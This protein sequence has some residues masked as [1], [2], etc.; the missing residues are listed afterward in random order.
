MSEKVYQL[1]SNQIG[2]I[3]FNKPWLFVHVSMYDGQ[4]EL[5][6]FFPTL[7]I[8]VKAFPSIFEEVVINHWK[9]QGPQGEEKIEA[10]RQYMLNTWWNPGIETMR[11]SMYEQYGAAEF[12]EKS[13]K[14][15]LYDGFG[16]LGLTV[17][18]IALRLNNKH[19]YFEGLHI[20]ARVVDKFLSV[21]FWEKIKTDALAMIGTTQLK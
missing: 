4:S 2:V 13:G 20:S 21:N 17:A 3:Q 9:A 19:F 11:K 7:D 15:L 18:H 1:N 6:E 5:N 12:K 16:F 10:L 14:D 8:G